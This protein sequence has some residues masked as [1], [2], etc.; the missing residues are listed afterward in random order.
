MLRLLK[1]AFKLSC[2]VHVLPLVLSWSLDKIQ[3][4]LHKRIRLYIW[5]ERSA[6][7]TLK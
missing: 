5:Y 3:S 7:L 6:K 1:M 2:Y 4:N